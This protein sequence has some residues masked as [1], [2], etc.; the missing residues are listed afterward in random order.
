[1]N[2][3][4]NGFE[5]LLPTSIR[6]S[7]VK[8]YHEYAP[9]EN[10]PDAVQNE[11]SIL[12]DV[13]HP[14]MRIAITAGSRGISNM[15]LIIRSIADFVRSCGADPFVIPAMG[16]HGGAN[17][18]GQTEVLAGYGITEEYVG[19]P[20][21]SSMEVVLIG[22]TEG[23]PAIPVFMDK[24]AWESNGVIVVNRVKPHTDFHGYHESGVVKMMTIGL[25]KHRQALEMH[26]HGASGLRDYIPRVTKVVIQ[27]GKILG[28]LGIVEDGYD[29]TS[30]LAFAQGMDIFDMDHRMLEQARKNIAKL[31]FDQL[32]LLVVDEMGKNY[33]GTNL[34]TN[35]IGR[36]CIRGEEDGTPF[37]RRIVTLDISDE[38]HG[39]ALGVGLSD[40][41]TSRLRDKID[42]NATLENVITSGF[43][44]RGFLPIVQ[45]TD[46][47]AIATALRGIGRAVA[48]D[49]IRM[50][51]IKSTLSLDEI[52]ISEAL[53]N[54]FRPDDYV[55][56]ETTNILL[57]FDE[58]GS[59]QTF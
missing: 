17:A 43:L 11:L 51:R 39:N 47:K 45:D 55:G 59:I 24:N 58:T 36:L 50:V 34:D 40:V 41:V 13:L 1:M 14:G 2:E 28:A 33:S 46:Q 22:T 35:V 57:S 4:S 37:C 32:D 27:S 5:R 16:S 56:A 30:Q 31:P 48:A 20:I 44:E 54:D 19:C 6:M 26:R 18:K 25:G 29:N 21:L 38:S 12:R 7:K 52:W 15:A 9:L 23:E 49:T 3:S 10:V 8:L 42:W 53:K